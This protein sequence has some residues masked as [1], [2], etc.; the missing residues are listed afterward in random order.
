MTGL[1]PDNPDVPIDMLALEGQALRRG[2]ARIAGVDEAGRGPLAGPV[3][4]AAVILPT[5]LVLPGVN[6]SKQLTEG[7]REEL[8]DVIHREALAVGVGIGDHALIDRINILQA[9]LSAMSDAVRGLSVNPDFLLID[10]I[11]SVPMNIPQRTVKKGDSLSLSIAAASIIAKVTRDRMMVE[12]DARFP[13]YG[14]ASHKGYGAASHLAAIAELGP[15]PIHRR[16]FSGVKEHC[17]AE[18][19]GASDAS[20]GLFSF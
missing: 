18:P 16:S 15:C 12:Y 2:Y 17:P 11:S 5:G 8:F 20:S 9:T 14:F 7:K 13:G 3:V 6:D 4:A 10:G 19:G 1:F